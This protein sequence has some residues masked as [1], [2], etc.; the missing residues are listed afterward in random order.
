MNGLKKT[1]R[2]NTQSDKNIRMELSV[3]LVQSTV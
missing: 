3:A 1:F 2:N